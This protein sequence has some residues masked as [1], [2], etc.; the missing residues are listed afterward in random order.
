MRKLTGKEIRL[1]HPAVYPTHTSADNGLA[2]RK[3]ASRSGGRSIA[4]AG[5]AGV[6]SYSK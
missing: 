3:R 4:T 2:A 1:I 6:L 5:G